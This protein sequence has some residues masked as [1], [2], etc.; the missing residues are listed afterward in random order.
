MTTPDLDRAMTAL[1][2]MAETRTEYTTGVWRAVAGDAT[3]A[4]N[5]HTAHLAPLLAALGELDASIERFSR[6]EAGNAVL[7]AYRAYINDKNT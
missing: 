6:L 7:D 5:A 1:R 2:D 4:Y 3:T